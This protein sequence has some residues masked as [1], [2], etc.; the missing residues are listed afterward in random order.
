MGRPSSPGADIEIG[1]Q[2][3]ILARRK[4]HQS[5]EDHEMQQGANQVLAKEANQSEWRQ[6]KEERRKS[7]SAS[8][9]RINK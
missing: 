8:H 1:N 4:R 2:R 9:C 5:A 7:S 3:R 6:G